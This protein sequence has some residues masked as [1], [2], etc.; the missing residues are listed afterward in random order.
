MLLEPLA[1]SLS[2]GPNGAAGAGPLDQP[3]A[4]AGAFIGA[5][6][7]HDLAPND[8][9]GPGFGLG[10]LDPPAGV[11]RRRPSGSTRWRTEGPLSTIWRRNGAPFCAAFA[12][13]SGQISA[14]DLPSLMAGFSPSEWRG[15]DCV[16]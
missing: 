14:A 10:R 6:V 11:V 1:Q 12:G 2:T 15:L 3:F 4:Q 5:G 9:V 8:P 13:V 7:W 16:V